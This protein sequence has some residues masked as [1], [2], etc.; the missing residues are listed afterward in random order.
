MDG[1]VLVEQSVVLMHDVV[2]AGLSIDEE[3]LEDLGRHADLCIFHL[4]ARGYA[5]LRI[6]RCVDGVNVAY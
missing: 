5:G 4:D 3:V 2:G 6:Q 1:S